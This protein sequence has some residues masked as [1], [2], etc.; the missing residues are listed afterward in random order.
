MCVPV[1]ASEKMLHCQQV[2]VIGNY[3]CDIIIVQNL[4]VMQVSYTSRERIQEL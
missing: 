4:P 1:A 3:S 2:T